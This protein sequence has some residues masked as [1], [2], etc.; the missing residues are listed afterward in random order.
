MDE[1]FLYC[2]FADKD[3]SGPDRGNIYLA[4]SF[5]F[6]NTWPVKIKVNDDI[7][8]IND[9]WQPTIAVTPDGTKLVVSFYD[10]RM[11][12][13]N[14]QIDYW[15]APAEINL[16]TGSVNFKHN[17]RIS[18]ESFPAVVGSNG[19]MGDYD[20]VNADD[21]NFYFAWGDNR[22]ADPGVNNQ[23]P[24]VYFAKTSFSDL[25][26]M[27]PEVVSVSPTGDTILNSVSSINI[28]FNQ[29][30]DTMTFNLANDV[31]SFSPASLAPTGSKWIND[32]TL[33]ITFAEQKAAGNYQLVLHPNVK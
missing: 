7:G 12:P 9:Q 28:V 30:M 13:C 6:G 16:T 17:L 1:R 15:A 20:V 21:S 23:G 27:G 18:T 32:H 11:D 5:D 8:G 2:V 19:Y 3:P 4:Q 22:D 26:K 14:R 10:R 31:Y 25:S 29:S 24:N 33:Q